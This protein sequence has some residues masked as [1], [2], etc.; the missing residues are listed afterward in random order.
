MD[1]NSLG[2]AEAFEATASTSGTVGILSVYVDASSTGTALVAGLY[3]DSAGHPGT[4][5]A[6]GALMQLTAGAW[7]NVPI[8]GA[9][10][11]AGTPYWLAILA[12]QS[13]VLRFRDGTGCTS[14]ESQQTNLTSL[15]ATWVSGASWPS[16][17][18]SA[19]GATSP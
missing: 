14:V 5:I 2:T 4:L 15:P 9:I 8:P 11:T 3:S 13:G 10:V 1:F 17:P 12:T 7:N 18:L 6:Q 19:Y 16:C